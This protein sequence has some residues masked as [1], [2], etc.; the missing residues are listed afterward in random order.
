MAEP[1]TEAILAFLSKNP[2]LNKPSR[3]RVIVDETEL[4]G[5]EIKAFSALERGQ[6]EPL[7][8]YLD[9]VKKHEHGFLVSIRLVNMLRMMIGT[10]GYRG[11]PYQLVTKLG[12][13]HKGRPKKTEGE[14]DADQFRDLRGFVAFEAAGGFEP[15]GYRDGKAVGRA[16]GIAAASLETG[17][18]ESTIRTTLLPRFLEI[19][20]KQ[21][22]FEANNIGLIKKRD[23]L[24]RDTELG[25]RHTKPLIPKE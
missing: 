4:Q 25:R 12:P 19:R 14:K 20:R 22:H 23:L 1:I 8:A 10:D 11:S 5:L 2:S 21:E 9:A 7:A 16:V 13:G 15:V 17:L 18:S 24:L 6:L 3:P